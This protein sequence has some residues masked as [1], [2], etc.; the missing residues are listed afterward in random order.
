M[1]G[2]TS[3]PSIGRGATLLAGAAAL[4]F[5]TITLV[6]AEGPAPTAAA[7]RTDAVRRGLDWLAGR[8][9][10][11]GEYAKGTSPG[12]SNN[13]AVTSLAGLAFLASGSTP[14]QGPYA[15]TLDVA[16][17]YILSCQSVETG[18]IADPASQ[19][20]MYAH[21][22]ATLFLAEIC[23]RE[24]NATALKALRKAVDLLSNTQNDAGGWRYQPQRRDADISVTACELNALL[25]A[26][27]AGIEVNGKTIDA[28]TAYIRKCQNPDGGFSYMAGQGV[29]SGLPRSA[30][31]VAVILHGGAKPSD[32]DVSRAINY[33]LPFFRQERR[34]DRNA[35]HYYYG[36]YY[37]SQ[38]LLSGGDDKRQAYDRLGAEVL[39]AQRPDGSWRDD[40][41][42]DYAT[43]NAL[44]ILQAPD[45][46][47]W[48]FGGAR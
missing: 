22:Y 30:A 10:K 16:L 12:F 17:R 4:L 1:R 39:A 26:R 33:I 7:K 14:E 48:A 18:L 28:A 11:Q 3:R 27:S 2:I 47:L 40:F 32:G 42:E 23:I 8:Q 34:G 43:A 5:C 41:S 29:G 37:A 31:A 36:M 15:K 19:P 25:A 24:K 35:G 46:K 13:V 9:G 44:I 21:G 38:W 45:R 20:P 6:A